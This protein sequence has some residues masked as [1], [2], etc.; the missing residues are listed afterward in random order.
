MM[1]MS[2]LQQKFLSYQEPEL[3]HG[4]PH[5]CQFKSWL[6]HFRYSSL[7]TFRGKQQKTVSL[8]GSLSPIRKMQI[9]LLAPV[10]GWAQ[11]QLLWPCREWINTTRKISLS[12]HFSKADF[13]INKY[14]LKQNETARKIL[15]WIL[16]I[17]IRQHQTDRDARIIWYFE[18]AIISFQ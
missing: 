16:K 5:G 12:L 18:A 11:P 3:W 6:H 7:L 9:K 1:K 14:I 10:F 15:N 2:R 4:I 17:R 8:F 13:Q